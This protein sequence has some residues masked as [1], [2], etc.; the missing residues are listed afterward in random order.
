[1]VISVVPFSLISA[2]QEATQFSCKLRCVSLL[3]DYETMTMYIWSMLRS[4]QVV[5]VDEGCVD[6]A[7]FRSC[8]S[9][10]EG[11]LCN[12]EDQSDKEDEPF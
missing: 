2:V 3:S 8:Y 7:N 6:D 9:Y 12:D 1:M 5:T 10:C 11:N 4:C